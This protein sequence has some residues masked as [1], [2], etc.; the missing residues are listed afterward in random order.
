MKT[1]Q[2]LP[3]AAANST[4]LP[5]VTSANASLAPPCQRL[6]LQ[7]VGLHPGRYQ[8]LQHGLHPLLV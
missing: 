6:D 4:E 1:A 2:P 8:H 7:R 5:I 3:F